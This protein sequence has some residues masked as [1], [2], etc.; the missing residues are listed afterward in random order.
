MN[1]NGEISISNLVHP[2]TGKEFKVL[3]R[4]DT[5]TLEDVY[6][7]N[8][9]EDDNGNPLTEADADGKDIILI[10]DLFFKR[11]QTVSDLKVQVESFTVTEKTA[12]YTLALSDKD[13]HVNMNLGV[14]G[15]LTVPASAVVDF[16]IGTRIAVAQTGAGQVTVAGASGVTLHSSG[17]KLKTAAQYAVARLTKIAVDTWLLDGDT[18]L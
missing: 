16:P 18:A 14:A 15:S 8:V 10:G 5:D 1:V 13:T 3:Y 9:F 4:L 6:Y 11:T 12:A 7:K 2:S 17:G